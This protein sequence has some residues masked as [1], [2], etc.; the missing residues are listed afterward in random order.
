M[1]FFRMLVAALSCRAV[2]SGTFT[3]D[4]GIWTS[5]LASRSNE[6]EIYALYAFLYPDGALFSLGFYAPQCY[7]ISGLIDMLSAFNFSLRDCKSFKIDDGAEITFLTGANCQGNITT[8]Y[9]DASSYKISAF[10]AFQ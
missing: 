8:I 3:A 1:R 2:A 10:Q 7:K 5:P 9:S 6:L 4:V